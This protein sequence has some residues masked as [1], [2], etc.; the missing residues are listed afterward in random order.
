MCGPCCST[1]MEPQKDCPECGSEMEYHYATADGPPS[2]GN[3]VWRCKNL[4]CGHEEEVKHEA[5]R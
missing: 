4:R 1:P 5:A 2:Y 3:P